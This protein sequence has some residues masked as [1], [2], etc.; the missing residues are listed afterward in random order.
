MKTSASER[1]QL[2]QA[3]LT[4]NH[5][6]DDDVRACVSVI[7]WRLSWR[8][9]MCQFVYVVQWLEEAG[10]FIQFINYLN[11]ENLLNQVTKYDCFGFDCFI[12]MF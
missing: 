8:M 4:Q 9:G 3:I 10:Y 6:E 12:T 1:R 5:T 2:L 7:L 11:W